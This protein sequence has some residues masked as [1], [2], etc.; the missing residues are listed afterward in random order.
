MD[1]FIFPYINGIIDLFSKM[2]FIVLMLFTLQK[3]GTSVAI[4]IETNYFSC[5]WGWISFKSSLYSVYTIT[6]IMWPMC[7]ANTH[8]VE[9]LKFVVAQNSGYSWVQIYIL[10]ENI[11]WNSYITDTE[12]WPINV[13]TSPGISKKEEKKIII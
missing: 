7:T 2:P 10:D 1:Y 8:T 5:G 13:I 9:S 4:T 11:I 6:N 12:N 3:K